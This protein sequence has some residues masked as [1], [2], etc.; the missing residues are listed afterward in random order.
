MR[1]EKREIRWG[2]WWRNDDWRER[3]NWKNKKEI[4]EWRREGINEREYS[5][6][7]DN[8]KWF[9]YKKD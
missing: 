9:Y 7:L 2:K 6:G 5:K 3:K 8:V 4:W 1:W